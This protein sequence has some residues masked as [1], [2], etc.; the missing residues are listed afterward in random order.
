[1]LRQQIVELVVQNPF[2]TF[3]LTRENLMVFP[4]T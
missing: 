2:V 4:I 1:M 3:E